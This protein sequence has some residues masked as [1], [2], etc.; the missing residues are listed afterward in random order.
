MTLSCHVTSR[1][2]ASSCCRLILLITVLY[3]TTIP[4]KVYLHFCLIILSPPQGF[5]SRET[6]WYSL[7]IS[8]LS[9]SLPKS[10]FSSYCLPWLHCYRTYCLLFFQQIPK[11]IYSSVYLFFQLL[12]FIFFFLSLFLKLLY[13]FPSIYFPFLFILFF[14]LP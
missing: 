9:L 11:G 12:T 10:T 6:P 13:F 3:P 7:S 1:S 5:S 14:P 8:S 2:C 4:T